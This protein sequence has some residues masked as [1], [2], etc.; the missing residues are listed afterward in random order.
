[1]T[2]WRKSR[3]SYKAVGMVSRGASRQDKIMR[4]LLTFAA[5][6]IGVGRALPGLIRQRRG[7]DQHYEVDEA[8]EEH[9]HGLLGAAWPCPQTQRLN[10]LMAEIPAL[11]AA[12]GLGFG[13][14]TYGCFS[15]ADISLCRAVWCTVLHARPEIVIETGVAHGVTSRIVLEAMNLNNHGHLWSIDLPYPFDHGV[16]VQTGAAITDACR[17]RWSYLEGSSKQRLPQLIADLGHVEIFI[18]DSLHTARNVMFEMQQA[19]SA[20]APGG[21]MLVDDIKTHEGF[22]AFARRHPEYQTTVCPSADRLGMFG[23]AVNATRA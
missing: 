13:R 20:M 21:I 15:D 9:L 7:I 4:L 23:I 22:A 11:L 1:M 10:E 12:Q 14:Y 19:A 8:W 16:H 18:H 6:P 17:P 2:D 5:H 3:V